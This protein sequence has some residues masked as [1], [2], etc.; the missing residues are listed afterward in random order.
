[1]SRATTLDRP[2]QSAP[3]DHQQFTL[4]ELASRLRQAAAFIESIESLKAAVGQLQFG[5]SPRQPESPAAPEPTPRRRQSRTTEPATPTP[6]EDTAAAKPT[7]PAGR[8]QQRLSR[9]QLEELRPVILDPRNVNR[10]T[11]DLVAEFGVERSW[12]YA[13]RQKARKAMAIANAAEPDTDGDA[14]DSGDSGEEDEG[15]ASDE[16]E[17]ARRL[18]RP[19]SGNLSRIAAIV[20]R[21]EFAGLSDNDLARRLGCAKATVKYARK[22]AVDDGDLPTPSPVGFINLPAGYTPTDPEAIDAIRRHSRLTVSGIHNVAQISM[23]RLNAAKA[24]LL[25]AQGITRYACLNTSPPS[26]RH[27]YRRMNRILKRCDKTGDEPTEEEDKFIQ[28]LIKIGTR[29]VQAGWLPNDE[30][31]RRTGL[32]AG[33]VDPNEHWQPPGSTLSAL[34]ANW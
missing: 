1:M 11:A 25:Q 18:G 33:E 24:E 26:E 32:N 20:S 4:P 14:A 19:R 8:K 13:V 16:E 29:D 15:E 9:S 7:R 21:P 3:P 30:R 17:P 5:D 23:S 10:P 27:L 2:H 22:R 12:V 34:G 31:R 6:A 28:E